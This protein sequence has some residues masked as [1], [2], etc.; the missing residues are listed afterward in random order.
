MF[1]FFCF[2]DAFDALVDR[3]NSSA[4]GK[5]VKAKADD[6]EF[7]SDFLNDPAIQALVEVRK[8]IF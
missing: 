5:Q 4:F 6:L 3:L 2:L 1:F 8:F 7:L